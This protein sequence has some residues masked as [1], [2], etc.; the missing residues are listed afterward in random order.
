ML[1]FCSVETWHMLLLTCINRA[2]GIRSDM[3]LMAPVRDNDGWVSLSDRSGSDV[4]CCLYG[5]CC[6]P[7]HL[8]DHC[9]LPAVSPTQTLALRIS[10][11]KPAQ[12]RELISFPSHTWTS[13]SAK[14]NINPF[15]LFSSFR[16]LFFLE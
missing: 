7:T 4:W 6:F 1:W 3:D 5:G 13:P 10:I 9:Q 11:H 8:P 15:P 2:D 12:R 16:E 14:V